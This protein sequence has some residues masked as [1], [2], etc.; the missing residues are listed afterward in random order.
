MSAARVRKTVWHFDSKA[1][2]GEARGR[3]GL[4]YTDVRRL[5]TGMRSE[6]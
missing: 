6:K 5:T 3:V 4:Q 2:L 1:R